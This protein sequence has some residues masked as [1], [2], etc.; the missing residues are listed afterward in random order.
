MNIKELYAFVSYASSFPDACLCLV[1]SFDTLKSGVPNFICVA[2]ALAQLGHQAIG[3][4]LDSG[5]LAQLSISAKEMF[6]QA[7]D[8]LEMREFTDKF[9]VVASNDINE[10]SI[11]KLN[12]KKH[13]IDVFGIGTNLVTCQK[14]PALGMVYKLVEIN[15]EPKIKFSEE[16]EKTTLPGKKIVFRAFKVDKPVFDLI[17]LESEKEVIE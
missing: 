3:V 15:Q 17:S 13:Q 16:L 5:D 6:K 4:R 11:L 1:D 14:Q 2:L 9:K 7:G 8:K 10:D 12:E